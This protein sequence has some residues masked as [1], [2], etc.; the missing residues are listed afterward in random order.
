MGGAVAPF[1]VDDPRAYRSQSKSGFAGGHTVPERFSE[2]P[3][4]APMIRVS[5]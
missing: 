5:C 3:C 4:R 2:S 1:A